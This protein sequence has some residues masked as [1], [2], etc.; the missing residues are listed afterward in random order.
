MSTVRSCVTKSMSRKSASPTNQMEAHWALTCVLYQC[1]TVT[2]DAF[3][4]GEPLESG[5]NEAKINAAATKPISHMKR[6]KLESFIGS[7]F[8]CR[9]A[10]KRAQVSPPRANRTPYVNCAPFDE[11]GQGR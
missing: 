8:T 10:E 6:F 5:P 4:P 9:S 1:A 11:K 7:P 3:S 2:P